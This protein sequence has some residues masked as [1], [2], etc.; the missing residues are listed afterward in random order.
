MVSK[1]RRDPP[2]L[3]LQPGRRQLEERVLLGSSHCGFCLLGRSALGTHSA[4]ET[5]LLPQSDFVRTTWL[6]LKT[7]ARPNLSYFLNQG[8]GVGIKWCLFSNL[9][10]C[11]FVF[12]KSICFKFTSNTPVTV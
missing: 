7:P 6:A 9:I 8:E 12:K 1:E 3:L 10:T 4:L 11:D 2:F 5:S